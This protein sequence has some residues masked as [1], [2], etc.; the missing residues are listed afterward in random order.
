MRLASA[1]CESPF[2]TITVAASE[3]GLAKVEWAEILSRTDVRNSA[4]EEAPE[5][6]AV[7]I[8]ESAAAQLAEYFHGQRR[9]FDVPLDIRGTSFQE[10]VWNALRQIPYGETRSYRD[11]ALAIGK[12]KAVRAVGQANRANPIAIV[13]P[14]HRVIGANGALTGYAGSQVHL[15]RILLDI[16]L[17][18]S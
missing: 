2:G 6:S 8:A 9:T 11:I 13:I 16:E 1:E 18:Q 17:Q 3:R 5:R 12:E 14:C 4:M 10:A 15:K 7:E